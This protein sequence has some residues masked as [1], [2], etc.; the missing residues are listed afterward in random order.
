MPLKD[1]PMSPTRPLPMTAAMCAAGSR[2]TIRSMTSERSQWPA[3]I[4]NGLPFRTSRLHMSCTPWM[5]WLYI[6]S[7]GSCPGP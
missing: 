2:R 1:V 4:R 3:S 5:P 6:S 7:A